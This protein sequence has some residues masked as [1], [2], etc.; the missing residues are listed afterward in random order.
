MPLNMAWNTETRGAKGVDAQAE[1]FLGLLRK[2]LISRGKHD[3]LRE[4]TA[5]I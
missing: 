5:A 2:C 4:D 3:S 1:E